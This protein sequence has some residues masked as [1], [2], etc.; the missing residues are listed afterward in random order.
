MSW[1]QLAALGAAALAAGGCRTPRSRQPVPA[2]VPHA[3]VT[4]VPPPTPATLPQQGFVAVAGAELWYRIAGRGPDTLLAFPAPY[5]EPFLV[6][7]AD[8]FTVVWYDP[9]SRGRSREL[10]GAPRPT[11][12]SDVADLETLRSHLGLQRVALLSFGYDAAV[13]VAYA[14][15]HPSRVSRMVLLSPIEPRDS[16]GRNYNP[17]ERLARLDTTRARNLV[18]LR[19]AG[20][21]SSDPSGYCRAFWEVNAPLLAA[22]PERLPHPPPWCELAAESPAHLAE[23]LAT[24]ILSLGEAY[25]LGREAAAVSCP[26]L[27]IA[28]KED[29]VYNPAAAL[30]WAA[31]LRDGRTWLIP[32]AGH[33][34]FADAS[35]TVAA[36]IARFLWGEWP[37]GVLRP[38]H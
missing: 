20:R 12:Q 19:A 27:V 1:R 4:A 18:R 28:G 5:L 11:F 14:A 34:V 10:L 13:A 38:L 36:A 9:R 32:G 25:D 29:L 7:P 21:D 37:S 17:A 35:D 15:S 16:L 30:L 22:H 6:L 26:V 3:P 23:R 31:L 24:A 33:L 2:T 8:R